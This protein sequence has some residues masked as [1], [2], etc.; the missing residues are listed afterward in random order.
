MPHVQAG[1]CA[2]TVFRGFALSLFGVCRNRR[3][4]ALRVAR[5]VRPAPSQQASDQ[6]TAQRVS[7]ALCSLRLLRAASTYHSAFASR[8]LLIP[9]GGAGLHACPVA[10]APTKPATVRP[11]VTVRCLYSCFAVK[12]FAPLTEPLLVSTSA[13]FDMQDAAVA[14]ARA[15]ARRV[16]QIA[17][18]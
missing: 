14:Q 4:W 1:A 6:P 13:L 15:T 12:A 16:R 9:R 10:Q 3:H 7:N 5:A 18:L 11:R 2:H 8:A 17:T